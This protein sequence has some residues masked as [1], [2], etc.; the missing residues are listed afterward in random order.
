[1]KIQFDSLI[2][3]RPHQGNRSRDV[4][5]P[6]VRQQIFDLVNNLIQ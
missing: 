4:L 2:N 5:D 1:M 6:S 3:I